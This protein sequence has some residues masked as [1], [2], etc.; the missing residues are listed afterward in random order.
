[1]WNCNLSNPSTD[2][3][4]SSAPQIRLHNILCEL[5]LL[6]IKETKSSF[7]TPKIVQLF[8]QNNCQNLQCP[9]LPVHVLSCSYTSRF[10]SAFLVLLKSEHLQVGELIV[11]FLALISGRHRH[12][13]STA[14]WDRVAE[15]H[16]VRRHNG[17]EQYTMFPCTEHKQLIWRRR[18]MVVSEQVIDWT[19]LAVRFP[20]VVEARTENKWSTRVEDDVVHD[21]QATVPVFPCGTSRFVFVIA[22]FL[23]AQWHSVCLCILCSACVRA[24]NQNQMS[25]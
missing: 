8:S 12:C 18:Q 24:V 6:K 16:N 2:N 21:W 20:C 19:R 7:V 17:A 22:L 9:V 23:R 10:L 4:K 13:G 11:K 5:K 15:E 3:L 1:M 25:S 14:A